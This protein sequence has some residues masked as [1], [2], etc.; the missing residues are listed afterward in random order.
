MIYS[1]YYIS[2]KGK[3]VYVKISQHALEQF[4]KRYEIIMGIV[5]QDIF[6]TLF[7]EFGR[8][9]MMWDLPP[10]YKLRLRRHGTDTLYFK[11]KDFVFVVQGET[12]K[13]VEII[14]E[15][16]DLNKL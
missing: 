9:G 16:R 3:R 11:S 13:T 4:A 2:K 10:K 5:P 1:P 7:Q 12:I 8:A 14:G 6:Q 15:Y